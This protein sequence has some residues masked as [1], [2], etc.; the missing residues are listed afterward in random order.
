MRRIGL[1]SGALVCVALAGILVVLAADVWRWGDAI[2]AD[3]VRYRSAPK[4]DDLWDP[5]GLVP[6]AAARSSL[7]ID[8][9]LAFRR[10]VREMRLGELEDTRSFDTEVLI[11]RAEA[12]TQ[13]EA[14]AAGEGDPARRSRAMTLVGVILLATPVTTSE[15]QRA[16]LTAAIKHLQTAIELDPDNEEA[17]FN[18][19]FALR[20]RGVGLSASGGSLPNPSGSPNTSRGAATGSPGSGY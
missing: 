4:A 5:G 18:L 16:A 1:V 11:H 17:K 20:R 9:D 2:A 15:E 8:D 12:Q 3:D 14:I 19:E 13:L 7:A 10:A 6:L